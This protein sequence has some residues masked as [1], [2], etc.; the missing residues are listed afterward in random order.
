MGEKNPALSVKPRFR[1]GDAVFLC[2]LRIH[3][4][5]EQRIRPPLRREPASL[6]CYSDRLL[7]GRFRLAEER[8]ARGEPMNEIRPA[9]RAELPGAKETG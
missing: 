2:S 5:A 6:S 7:A 1:I 3:G 9:Y 8:N 4:A